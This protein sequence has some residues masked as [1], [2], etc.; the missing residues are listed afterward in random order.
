MCCPIRPRSDSRVLARFAARHRRNRLGEHAA[1][2]QRRK[3]APARQCGA[4]VPGPEPPAYCA[5]QPPSIDSGAPVIVCAESEHRNT[6]SPPISSGVEKRVIACFSDR[7]S[8]F[9]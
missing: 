9:T 3:R 5:T 4:G 2:R 7:K 8:A 6:A 1:T